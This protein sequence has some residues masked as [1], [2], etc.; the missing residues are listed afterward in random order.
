MTSRI[1]EARRQREWSQARLIS[2]LERVAARGGKGLPSRETLK[3][4]ISRWEN[5]HATPDEYYRRLL[6]EAFGLDDYELG[7]VDGAVEQVATAVEELRARLVTSRKADP[8]LLDALAAQ[9]EAIRRQDRQ[10]GARPLL[11][12]MRAHVA[13]VEQHVCH[14]AFDAC[15]QPLAQLLA[16]AAALAAW[17]ALDLGA[18]DQAWRFFETASRAA[19][20]A[21][22]PQLYAFSR[23]EQAHVLSDLASAGVAAEL[24]TSVW[25]HSNKRVSLPMKCWLAAGTAEMLAAANEQAHARQMIH[26]SESAVDGL[27]TDRPPYLVFDPTHLERWVGHTLTLLADGSAEARLRQVQADMDASFTRAGA[28][29]HLDLATVL[30][31]KRRVD[32]AI[33]ELDCAESLARQV[34]SRRQL[35]RARRLR[36]TA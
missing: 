25:E 22:D 36:A 26:L 28:G 19:Q 18:T 12:Q 34:G 21:G 16:D 29:L 5:N 4:R 30:L 27:R 33:W 10:Y 15:R 8:E 20:Q 13:N 6:R 31:Q 9:T 2:E 1:K 3:S 32:Q 35:D 11:E 17:Q 23:M 24:A 7:F 14:A